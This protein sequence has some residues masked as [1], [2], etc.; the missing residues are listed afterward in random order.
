[1]MQHPVQPYNGLSPHTADLWELLVG[2]SI[3]C[4][5]IIKF[6]CSSEECQDSTAPLEPC[7]PLEKV[8]KPLLHAIISFLA[9]VPCK[10][11]WFYLIPF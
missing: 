7:S 11:I 3:E 5:Q 10:D 4:L 1:M 2:C 8:L 6:N 9:L